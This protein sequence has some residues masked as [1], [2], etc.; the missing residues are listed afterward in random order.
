MKVQVKNVMSF[1]TE[2]SCFYSQRAGRCK[3]AGPT[4]VIQLAD[5]RVVTID[6]DW[7]IIFNSLSDLHHN[8]EDLGSRPFIRFKRDRR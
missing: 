6:D 2:L 1:V 4:D 7:L 5:G 8:I 3:E